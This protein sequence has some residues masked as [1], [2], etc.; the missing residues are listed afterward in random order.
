MRIWVWAPICVG[1]SGCMAFPETAEKGAASIDKVID[2]IDCELAAAAISDTGKKRHLDQWVTLSDLDIT[3][4]RSVSADGNVQVGFP[5]GLA[6]MTGKPT[7]GG[8]DTDTRINSLKF[9]RS[10]AKA[11]HHFDGSCFGPNPSETNM[12]LANWIEG[13]LE[14]VDEG[15]LVA[16]SFTKQF[17]IQVNGGARFGYVLVPVTNTVTA[18]A[19]FSTYRDYTNRFTIALTPPGPKPKPTQVAVVSLPKGTDIVKQPP[20]V[21]APPP[22]PKKGGNAI[23]PNLFTD[24]KDVQ[25]QN[26][27]GQLPAADVPPPAPPVEAKPPRRRERRPDA[28]QSPRDRALQDQILQNQLGRQSPFPLQR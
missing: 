10:I 18:D 26:A 16:V 22:P 21:P 1:L 25:P 19:G 11:V 17:K 6:G 12:G 2:S 28:G 23:G 3:L 8:T 24:K 15:S 20:A 14:A 13:T 7:I 5:V 27:P 9:A 4:E